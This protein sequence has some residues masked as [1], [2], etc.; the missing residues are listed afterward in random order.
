MPRNRR[1]RTSQEQLQRRFRQTS[2]QKDWPSDPVECEIELTIRD[3]YVCP[4]P[5]CLAQIGYACRPL[6]D[7]KINLYSCTGRY[8]LAL[9]DGLVPPRPGITLN[10]EDSNVRTPDRQGRP[11]IHRVHPL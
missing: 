11:P 3:N 4:Q 1:P 2:S 9:A 6:D 10:E 8:R 5:H 7:A